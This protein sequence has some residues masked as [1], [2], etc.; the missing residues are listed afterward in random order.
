[1]YRVQGSTCTNCAA[2]FEKNVRNLPGIQDVQVNFGA[3]KVTV[4][5]NT[6]VNSLV[7]AGAF[8]NLKVT[9]EKERIETN[10][11]PF[12]KE[13]AKVILSAV[14]LA[15]GYFL[16]GGYAEFAY[17]LLHSHWRL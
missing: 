10:K 15:M 14:L 9:P 4:Y 3:A 5:G 17:A 6:T 2:I 16:G 1:V 13:N 11:K 8:E 7:Q 12:W